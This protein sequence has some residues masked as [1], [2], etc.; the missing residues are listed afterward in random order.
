MDA[1]S[2]NKQRISVFGLGSLHLVLVV[3]AD[4]S[5]DCAVYTVRTKH[6]TETVLPNKP[7]VSVNH[8]LA[9]SSFLLPFVLGLKGFADALEHWDHPNA[10]ACLWRRDVELN[11]SAVLQT[12]NQVVVDGDNII[13]PDDVLPPKAEHLTNAAAGAEETSEQR[14]P[15]V[16]LFACLLASTKDIKA[17]CCGSVRP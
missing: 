17:F 16:V 1:E 13:F 7:A 2:R 14:V 3:V 12:V 15:M 11:L 4:N 6:S 10:V 9:E 8:I 5:G